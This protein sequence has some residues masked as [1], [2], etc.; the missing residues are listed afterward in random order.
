[1]VRSAAGIVAAMGS[2]CFTSLLCDFKIHTEEKK[3]PRSVGWE[4]TIPSSWGRVTDDDGQMQDFSIYL[5][6]LFSVLYMPIYKIQ[7]RILHRKHFVNDRHQL[8]P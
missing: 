4:G 3:A 7:K 8:S 2:C 5:F 1:M 6:F